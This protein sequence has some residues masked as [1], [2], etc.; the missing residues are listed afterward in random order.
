MLGVGVAA[1]RRTSDL[2]DYILGGRRLGPWTAALSAGASDMSGWLL[3]G[4]PGAA[5]ANGLGAGWIAVGLLI[6]T[7]ANWRFMAPRLRV[8]TWRMND[9]LT[10]PEFLERRFQTRGHTLR[11]VSAAFILL[12]FLFYTASGLVAGGKLFETVFGIPYGLAVALGAL[13]VIS[14][15]LLGGFLAVS[16]TD[17]IQGLL[18]AAA[19]V[20]LPL[21]VLWEL[22]GTAVALDRVREVNPN[23]LR[24]FHDAEGAALGVA[25]IVGTAAWG[26]GY[27]GQ[28]HILA[29]FAAIREVRRIGAARRIAVTWTALTLGCAM[30]VGLLGVAHFEGGLADGERIFLVLV[31]VM[32]HP[33]VAG[34]LLAAV[35]AAVMSTADSQLLVCSAAFTEDIYRSFSSSTEV[36][37]KRLVLIG[38]VSV[39]GVALAATA[40]ALRENATVLGMVAYAWAGFGATFGPVLLLSLYWSR[41]TAAGAGAGMIAG[42]VTVVLWRNLSGGLFDIYELLPGFLVGAA[43]MVVASLLSAPPSESVR[44]KF[45]ECVEDVL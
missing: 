43:V 2:S 25:G 14:Y 24:P 9:A 29:R 12:F 8:F 36:D 16:W 38:R 4:L 20:A 34:I 37:P 27:F 11:W 5:Y 22:G 41:A 10:L 1:Y 33:V 31:D 42:G 7:W 35:L 39:V 6:G 18:M 40:I 44:G 26:L 15:T 23:L 21:A 45:A 17:L 19:L 32:F 28:P 13:A 3:M 30:A